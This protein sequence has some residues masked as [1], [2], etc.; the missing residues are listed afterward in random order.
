MGVG[1]WKGGGHGKTRRQIDIE[2]FDIYES[3]QL[4][5]GEYADANYAEY[6]TKSTLYKPSQGRGGGLNKPS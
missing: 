5:Y 6:F 1:G 4:V 2:C 3:I